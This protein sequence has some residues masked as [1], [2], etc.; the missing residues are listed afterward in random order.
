MI[1]RLSTVLPVS[2]EAL[3]FV[4]CVVIFTIYLISEQSITLMYRKG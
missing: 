1:E 2:G 3:L 4:V